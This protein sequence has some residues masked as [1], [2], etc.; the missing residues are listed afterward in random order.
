MVVV[1]GPGLAWI[2][3]PGLH[4]VRDNS[5]AG[6]H[7]RWRPLGWQNQPAARPTVQEAPGAIKGGIDG[8]S[9]L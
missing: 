7:S 5:T 2:A 3:L 1:P 6:M 8:P 9:S 4:D